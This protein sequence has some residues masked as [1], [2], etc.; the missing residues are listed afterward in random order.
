MPGEVS[1]RFGLHVNRF[2]KTASRLELDVVA[3][4]DGGG[5]FLIEMNTVY[6]CWQHGSYSLYSVYTCTHSLLRLRPHYTA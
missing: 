6:V 5:R 2:S 4:T 3:A 1:M